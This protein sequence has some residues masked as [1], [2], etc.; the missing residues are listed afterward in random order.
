MPKTNAKPKLCDR[1]RGLR[2]RSGLSPYAL[3]RK[4]G[5]APQVYYR[6][7][8]GERPDPRWSSVCAIADALGVATDELRTS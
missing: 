6:I 4:A 7:E 5:L 1:L 8:S 3:A 2:E